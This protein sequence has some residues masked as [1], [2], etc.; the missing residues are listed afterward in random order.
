MRPRVWAALKY[1]RP[2]PY[3]GRPDTRG[4][5]Q[6]FRDRGGR[7]LGAFCP[8]GRPQTARAVALKATAFVSPERHRVIATAHPP[9][10]TD[11]LAGGRLDSKG[12]R[13]G[14][15]IKYATSEFR[16]SHLLDQVCEMASTFHPKKESKGKVWLQNATLVKQFE[17]NLKGVS[18]RPL[19]TLAK[20]TSENE[21]LRIS[22][23][24]FC[25]D[26][27]EEREEDLAAMIKA[28]EI[29]EA[30]RTRVCRE[31]QPSCDSDK[32]FDLA[33]K[34]RE[35]ALAAAAEAAAE[36]AAGDAAPKRKRKRKKKRAGAAGDL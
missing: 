26:M 18:K 36:A 21:L 6:P 17:D 22:L 33:S 28:G 20:A 2:A 27:I 23:L 12:V 19:P 25:G 4:R 31:I 10:Q 8:G 9:S 30:G 35:E 24:T 29:D 32:K 34:R 5:A 7:R 14:T 11:I 3:A 13:Q 16:T 1:A 15:K